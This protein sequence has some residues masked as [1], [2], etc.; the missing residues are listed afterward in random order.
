MGDP[1]T[2]NRYLSRLQA[3]RNRPERAHS[4]EFL[5]EQF[6]REVAR[7]Y[8]QFGPLGELWCRMLPEELAGRTRLES[9]KRGILQVS[10]DSSSTLYAIDRL[11]RGGLERRLIESHRQGSLR[12]VRLRVRGA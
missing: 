6:E 10:V 2:A 9:F 12:G 1:D 4:L 8:R 11:L 5:K 7:P 3:W